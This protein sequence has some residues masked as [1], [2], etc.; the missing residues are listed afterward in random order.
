M[1][2]LANVLQVVPAFFFEGM[3]DQSKAARHTP[4]PDY[5]SEMLAT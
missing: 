2:Q 3:P 1:Q 4:M 5:A